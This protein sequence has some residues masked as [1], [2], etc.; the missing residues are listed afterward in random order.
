[1]KKCFD[2]EFGLFP[3]RNESLSTQL[4]TVQVFILPVRPAAQRSN[5]GTLKLVVL[6]L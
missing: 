3:Y 2:F 6:S 1:M 4:F 5:T